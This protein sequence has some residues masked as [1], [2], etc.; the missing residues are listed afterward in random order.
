MKDWRL[1]QIADLRESLSKVYDQA[2][3]HFD[4]TSRE[5]GEAEK[6]L[7]TVEE[8]ILQL[9]N[10]QSDIGTELETLESTIAQNLNAHDL[11]RNQ[12]KQVLQ[13]DLNIN[14]ER[15]QLNDYNEKRSGLQLQI[16]TL[17]IE[18]AEHPFDPVALK[19]IQEQLSAL[20]TEKD[21]LNKEHGRA[22]SVLSS[23]EKQW[24]QKLEHQKRHDELDLRKQ[25]LK[26]MDEMFRA[27]GFVNYVSSVY[28]KNLCESANERF[29]KLTN[30]QLRLEL[31]EKNNFLVR[32]YLNSGE[33]RSVKTLSGGQ[34]FQAALSLALA[35][36]DNIQHLTKAKQNLFFLDEG[37]GTLDKDSLQTVFKTLKALRSEN[38]VVGIISHVEELQQEVDN[39][40]DRERKPDCPKLGSRLICHSEVRRILNF[41][42]S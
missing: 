28:L 9:R 30:N 22:T 41:S 39:F 6:E 25:D 38:R 36:S 24:Q 16:N 13:S 8:Q 20:Q 19:T 11:T 26:K 32:D 1:D 10:Q 35:L 31:D 33:V 29:F 17:E 27:Q 12:V 14:Q 2:K 23:L 4:D 7:A 34:T 40:I 21:A 3:I 42:Y 37:F 5:Q 15:Q 18:L